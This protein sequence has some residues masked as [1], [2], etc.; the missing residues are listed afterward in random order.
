VAAADSLQLA[1]ETLELRVAERTAQLSRLNTELAR[2]KADAEAANQGKTRFFAAASHDILQPLNAARLFTSTLVESPDLATDRVVIKNVDAALDAVEDILSTVLDMSRIDAGAIKPELSGFA[3]QELFDTLQR[4]YQPLAHDRG[5]EL[6]FVR[7][8][9]VLKS[10]RKLLRRVLQNLVSNAIKYT[11]QGGV[12]VGVRRRGAN[13]VICVYDT[14]LGIPA[15]QLRLVFREFERLGRD[16]HN[17]PGLGLGLSIVERLSKVLGHPLTVD[18]TLGV[19]TR[20]TITVPA[21]KEEAA[22]EVVVLSR[23]IPAQPL[24]G[25]KVLAIDNERPIVEGLTALLAAWGVEVVPAFRAS[26]ALE[27]LSRHGAS[28][29]AILADYHID[30]EDGIALVQTLRAK[31]GWS[32]PAIL[33]TA[34]RSRKVQDEAEAAGMQYLRKP[35]KPASLRACLSQIAVQRSAAE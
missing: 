17:E 4:E 28:I 10:D 19:G 3:V 22:P 31:A 33:I 27:A 8:S 18:S 23:A 15:E 11:R 12:L 30:S 14:G 24:A 1:N 35:V 26:D 32:L 9:A 29:D 16:K 2:A 7:S 34:D 21:G 20:F 13:F 6:R 25:M 5:L